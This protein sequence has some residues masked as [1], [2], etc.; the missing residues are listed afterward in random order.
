MF[1]SRFFRVLA[2]VVGVLIILV[3]V[4]PF[5]VPVNQF[6]PTIEHKASAALGRKVEVGN[7]SL[8]LL[9]GS[10][11]ADN[12][13]I[14]DDPKFSTSPFLTAKSVKVGVELMPL[15]F[16]KALNITG[17][18][19]DTPQVTLLRNPAGDWNYSSFGASAGKS[20]GQQTPA[21]QQPAGQSKSEGGEFSVAKLEL[22]NR[23]VVVGSTHSQKRSKYDQVSVTASNV[24]LTTRFPVTVSANLPGGGNL[25][26][27]G[28]AGPIDQ[29]NAALTP[30]DAK[31][32]VNS[33]NL[34]TTGFLDPSLGL[35]GVLD[36]NASI[37]SQNGQAQVNGSGKLSKALFVAGGG[38]PPPPPALDI[39]A[40][41]G[42]P[43]KSPGVAAPNL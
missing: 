19:I 21:P 10:L 29:S 6:R 24:A 40:R 31:P 28:Q 5:L 16:S 9:S 11:A 42:P 23:S 2:I 38:P 27:Q 13:S 37:G 32:T 8:S 14:E 43:Q 18:T 22:R 4:L 20:Q 33:F 36:L 17:V 34:A 41:G 39:S 12:L 30:V 3:L 15:I 26:L 35:G 7:L 25:K 1:M